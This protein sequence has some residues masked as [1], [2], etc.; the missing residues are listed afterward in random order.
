MELHNLLK[1]IAKASICCCT[2]IGITACINQLPD[3]SVLVAGD[4]PISFS[5][6]IK[7]VTTRVTNTAFEKDDRMG[8]FAVP[9]SKSLKGER[10]IDN[11]LLTY[12][13]EE[14]LRP[15]ETVFYPEGNAPL[16]FISYHP[17]QEEGITAGSSNLR[18]SVKANQTG[19]ISH[20]LS[21]FM[22]A[23]T[24]NVT[25]KGKTVSLKYEHKFANLQIT[26]T[27]D[28]TLNINEMI[29][30]NPQ[31]A[32]TGLCTSA[33]YDLESGTFSE[34]GDAKDILAYGNWKEKD[35]KLI[36]KEIIAIP[37]Q[38]T[39][40]SAQYLVME[41]NGRTYT[42]KLPNMEI[43]GGTKREI[44]ITA[45]ESSS[46]VLSCFEGE[47]T[48]WN[49]APPIET[50][51]KKEYNT[52]HTGV[53][54]FA[55]SEVY[56]VY[57]EGLPVAE[58]C[59]E[60]LQSDALTT[61][62]IV[63]Y[64]IVEGKTDHSN[65]LVLIRADGSPTCGGKLSWNNDG[66][67]FTYT[68]GNM[69]SVECFYIGS[70]HR[71]YLQKPE[72]ALTI[73][74]AAYTLRDTRDENITEYPIVKIGTQYWMA[75]NLRATAYRNGEA[76]IKQ[77]VLGTDKAGY[78]KPENAEVYF[79]NGEA[80]LAGE[81]APQGW[82]LPSDADW[83][84]L[85]TYLD[86]DVSA[87]KAGEKEGATWAALQNG[88]VQ[89]ATNYTYFNAQPVGMWHTGAQAQAGK[90]ACYWAWDYTNNTVSSNTFN[91]SGDSN[92]FTLA[93]S[94]ISGQTFYKALSIRCIKK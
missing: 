43:V 28:E 4:T 12:T 73:Q 88:I 86:N 5:G 31:I 76:L 46:D 49:N 94:F 74:V 7:K 79:Y 67:D 77:T 64:P 71:L 23:T 21:D 44:D 93:N 81:M 36:G 10:Y 29:Q 92:E 83:T 22:V 24:P 57:S 90:M 38:I 34:L 56:Q 50:D 52:V 41:W 17:Y 6:K 61:R 32:I 20:S 2:L 51:N 63:A 45:T 27:P 15:A 13:E 35:G 16:D 89:P 85:Q 9:A 68:P 25:D 69:A 72:D 19:R 42:C 53:L 47:V 1:P 33:N 65:G 60:Y 87:L 11:L 75:D 14:E 8:V 55:S 66:N 37:Q 91:L 59:R 54:L 82:R 26:I 78:F 80:L 18:V 40:E 48:D 84:Q 3:T 30:S 58:I 62:A 39:D 70:D